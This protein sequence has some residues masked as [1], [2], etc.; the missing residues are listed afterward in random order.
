VYIV[1]IV[2]AIAVVVA[3]VC[4]AINSES[5]KRFVV[6]V[7]ALVNKTRHDA[8]LVALGI[9]DKRV[10]IAPSDPAVIRRTVFV[11]ESPVIVPQAAVVT[12][13]AIFGVC[14]NGAVKVLAMI[15]L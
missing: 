13:V 9:A 15:V 14:A 12:A 6:P 10:S 7:S 3:R 1:K 8:V 4:A 11:G 5:I 2:S